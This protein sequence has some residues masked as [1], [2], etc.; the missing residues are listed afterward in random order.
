MPNQGEQLYITGGG[1]GGGAPSGPAGGALAGTYPNPTLN[2]PEA[3]QELALGK[4]VAVGFNGAPTW[5]DPGAVDWADVTTNNLGWV[6]FAFDHGGGSV[7][8]TVGNGAAILSQQFA[9]AF[10]AQ[11]TF[12]N[13][14]GEMILTSNTA[15]T[16]LRISGATG[17]AVGVRLLDIQDGL[18][19]PLLNLDPTGAVGGV[20]PTLNGAIRWNGTN[21]EASAI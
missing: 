18:G 8:V 4:Y 1:G 5:I 19:N 15:Q 9:S 7:T 2:A 6:Q 14:D 13:N 12:T 10:G 3:S 16:G 11:L 20:A 21:W 17:Q